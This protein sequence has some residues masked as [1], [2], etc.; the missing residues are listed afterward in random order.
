VRGN[1]GECLVP[2]VLLVVVKY[3]NGKIQIKQR[4]DSYNFKQVEDSY[5]F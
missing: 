3:L 4:E 1:C 5:Y 2:I